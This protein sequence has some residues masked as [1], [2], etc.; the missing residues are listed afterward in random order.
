MAK[1]IFKMVNVGHLWKVISL[2]MCVPPCYKWRHMRI[3]QRVLQ[4]FHWDSTEFL[5]QYKR[6]GLQ[7]D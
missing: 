4:S 2:L 7:I 6:N 3:D 1:L 5:I